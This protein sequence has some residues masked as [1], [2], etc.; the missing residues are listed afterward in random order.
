MS[1]LKA[2]FLVCPHCGITENHKVSCPNNQA[3]LGF[4]TVNP[5]RKFTVNAESV[6]PDVLSADAAFR[7]NVRC[8]ILYDYESYV[9]GYSQGKYDERMY[10][11]PPNDPAIEA[12]QAENA[13]LKADVNTMSVAY[14]S[15][16]VERDQLQ[17]ERLKALEDI[18]AMATV[19]ATY[20]ELMQYLQSEID[21]AK[22][23]PEI[24]QPT[25]E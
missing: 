7:S 12:L 3:A 6:V 17:A 10:Q 18:A 15:T 25:G 14:G 8:Q 1:D 24:P 4:E 23:H 2:T 11:G 21:K 13:R 22:G 5:F 9:S 16:V 19:G 20:P